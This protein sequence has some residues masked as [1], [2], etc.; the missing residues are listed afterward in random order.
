MDRRYGI[1]I[2]K[3][4][5]TYFKELNSVQRKIALALTGSYKTVNNEKLLDLIKICRLNEEA[6]IKNM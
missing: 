2:L 6:E 3:I 1:I 5:K 4:K